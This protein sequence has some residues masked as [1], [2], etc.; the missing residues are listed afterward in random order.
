MIFGVP[1]ESERLHKITIRGG[2]YVAKNGQ[3]Y[4]VLAH[5][6]Y[7]IVTDPETMTFKIVETK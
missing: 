5:K 7:K 6:R 3:G 4:R 1:P 2:D